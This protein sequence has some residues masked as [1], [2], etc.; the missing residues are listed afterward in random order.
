MIATKFSGIP[1]ENERKQTEK[2][3]IAIADHI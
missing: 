1:K 3:V 2:M